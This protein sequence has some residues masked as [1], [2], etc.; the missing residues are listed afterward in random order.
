MSTLSHKISF[1]EELDVEARLFSACFL[2]T[3]D[4]NGNKVFSTREVQEVAQCTFN[5]LEKLYKK[6]SEKHQ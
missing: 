2:R 1:N 3:L 6:T 4:K 5:A